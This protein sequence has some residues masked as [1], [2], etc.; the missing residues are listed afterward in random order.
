MERRVKNM[1]L[2]DDSTWHIVLFALAAGASGQ[3]VH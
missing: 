2:L 3:G 1:R